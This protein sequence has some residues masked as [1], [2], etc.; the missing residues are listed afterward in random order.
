VKEDT[1]LYPFFDG[2]DHEHMAT[3]W[4]NIH[5]TELRDPIVFDSLPDTLWV[6]NDKEHLSRVRVYA[7]AVGANGNIGLDG[8]SSHCPVY[9]Y[10]ENGWATSVTLQVRE[11]GIASMLPWHMEKTGIVD[12][13]GMM[14]VYVTRVGI[15]PTVTLEATAETFKDDLLPNMMRG[16]VIP[17]PNK[18]EV[19]HVFHAALVFPNAGSRIIMLLGRSS[20]Y[21]LEKHEDHMVFK[22]TQKCEYL[23]P[24]V[25]SYAGYSTHIVRLETWWEPRHELMVDGDHIRGGS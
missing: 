16:L 7:D 8:R 20:H 3:V 14:T 24:W 25:N 18:L 15:E 4:K 12:D 17:Y 2:T 5:Y 1:P 11:G 13:T 6:G 22:P 21:D 19:P 23:E 9:A 10:S